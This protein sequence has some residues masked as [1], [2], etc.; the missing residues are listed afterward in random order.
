MS[1]RNV[2]TCDLYAPCGP[3]APIQAQLMQ[4]AVSGV[5]PRSH[6]LVSKIK[7]YMSQYANYPLPARGGSDEKLKM[8][9]LYASCNQNGH[10][11][12]PFARIYRRASLGPAAVVIPA[13][14]AYIKVAAV[15]KLVVGSG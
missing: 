6:I 4:C 3:N 12:S 14:I 10:T 11:L 2:E 13:P 7:P 1:F 15:K 8:R 5:S 9:E